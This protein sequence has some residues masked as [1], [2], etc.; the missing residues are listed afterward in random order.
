M[1]EH[2][3]FI[4]ITKIDRNHT[5]IESFEGT[6]RVD[7]IGRIQ[8]ECFRLPPKSSYLALRVFNPSASIIVNEFQNQFFSFDFDNRKIIEWLGEHAVKLVNMVE[9]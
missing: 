7:G 2:G 4:E 9:E 6:L 5:Y 1:L 3:L 8:F